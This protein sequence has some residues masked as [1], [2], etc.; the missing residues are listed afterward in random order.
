MDLAVIDWCKLFGSD[1]A[2]RQ[3]IHWKNIADD[4]DSFRSAL[5]KALAMTDDDWETY[6][7]SMKK[8]RDLTAAHY[9]PRRAEIATYPV[10]DKA[11]DSALFYFE[12]IQHEMRKLGENLQPVDVRMYAKDFETECLTVAKIALGS[13]KHIS[14]TSGP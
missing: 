11:L 12:Y 9:D 4:Q 3:S 8:Y 10:L 13:T 1:D 7:E 14:E 2:E 6:W 5:L